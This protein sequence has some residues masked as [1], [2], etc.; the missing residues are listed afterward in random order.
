M[1]G[2]IMYGEIV[3]AKGVTHQTT[4]IVAGSCRCL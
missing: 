2:K 3:D 1:S 4:S